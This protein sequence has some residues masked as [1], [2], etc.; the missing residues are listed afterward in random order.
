MFFISVFEIN[1]VANIIELRKLGKHHGGDHDCTSEECRCRGRST[2]GEGTGGYTAGGH[3]ARRRRGAV[4]VLVAGVIAVVV[5]GLGG[6]IVIMLLVIGKRRRG[7]RRGGGGGGGGSSRGQRC[8]VGGS[9]NDLGNEGCRC[10]ENRSLGAYARINFTGVGVAFVG[11]D[12]LAGFE[13]ESAA[14]LHFQTRQREN[15]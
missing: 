10:S 3:S 6:I 14:R 2:N 7:R 5:V 11:G 1:R 9:S 4:L 15:R 8:C 12:D 13:A